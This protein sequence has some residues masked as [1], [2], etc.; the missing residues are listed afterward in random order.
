MAIIGDMSTGQFAPV[1]SPG[2]KTKPQKQIITSPPPQ[3]FP[4]S[5]TSVSQVLTDVNAG[6]LDADTALD[7][8]VNQFGMDK[9]QAAQTIFDSTPTGQ[10]LADAFETPSLGLVNE[11]VPNPIATDVLIEPDKE[12]SRR[13]KQNERFK[14]LG[15]AILI[16]GWIKL[17]K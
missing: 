12:V 13:I 2:Y 10:D 15:M 9:G 3:T 17:K 5:Y 1:P 6:V 4:N 8:L 11:Y 16:L 7:I 14:I